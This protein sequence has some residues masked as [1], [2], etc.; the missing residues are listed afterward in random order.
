MKYYRI[1]YVDAVYHVTC[2]C[3]NQERLFHEE[4]AFAQYLKIVQNC[5]NKYCFAIYN[6]AIM[7]NHVHI[8]IKPGLVINISKIMHAINRWYA[9]WYNGYYIR[10]GH[11]WEARFDSV[12]IKDDLQLLATMR[13]IDNNPVRAGLCTNST[14]WKYSGANYFLKGDLN[15]LLDIPETYISLGS[16]DKIRQCAYKSI[17][18]VSI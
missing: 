1:R 9:R 12:V 18:S 2:R 14:E 6:Y 4:H 16:T 3:N 13:Y 8:I 17:V 7:G 10:K 5:K 15:S 11:F